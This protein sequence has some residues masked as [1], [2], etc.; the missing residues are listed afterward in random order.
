M[1]IDGREENAAKRI[2]DATEDMCTAF[3]VSK[4]II[5]D[6]MFCH[7]EEASWPMGTDQELM[8]KFDKIFGTTDYNNAMDRIRQMQKQYDGEIKDKGMVFI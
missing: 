8:A 3:G 5:N 2:N 6:V 1:E 4:A 7:Q